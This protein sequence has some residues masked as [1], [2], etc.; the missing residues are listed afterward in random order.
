MA[1]ELTEP[2]LIKSDFESDVFHALISRLDFSLNL[3]IIF[4]DVDTDKEE[5]SIIIRSFKR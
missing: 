3:V 1:A 5:I 2:C 4:N